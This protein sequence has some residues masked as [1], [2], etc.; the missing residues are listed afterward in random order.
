[1][2]EQPAELVDRRRVILDSQ[3]AHAVDPLARL[4]GCSLALDDDR[5]GLLSA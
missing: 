1:M 5:G 2:P 3:L 4:G